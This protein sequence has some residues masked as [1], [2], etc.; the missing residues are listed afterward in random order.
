MK[1]HNSVD[2][3]KTYHASLRRTYEIIRDEIQNANFELILQMI[4][5]AVNDSV[6]SNDIVSILLVFE[7]Y[8]RMMNDL[9]SS[10]FI[11]QRIEIIRKEMKE[12]HRLHA[13]RQ[14]KDALAMRNESNIDSI[15]SLF[16]QSDVRVWRE[17]ND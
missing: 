13:E 10:S 14:M 15:I 5:K 16:I 17:K 1:T 4:V 12:I 2:K 9:S 3:V 7:T 6:D 8:S 11:V